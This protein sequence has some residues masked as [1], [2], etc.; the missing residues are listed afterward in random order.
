MSDTSTAVT[1]K[2]RLWAGPVQQRLLARMPVGQ[3]FRDSGFSVP[4]YCNQL[5]RL[6]KL[7]AQGV[8]VD[9]V[10]L[11]QPDRDQLTLQARWFGPQPNMLLSHGPR[12]GI[13]DSAVDRSGRGSGT[14]K[15]VN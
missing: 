2:D 6:N 7:Q 1:L 3:W 9:P 14:W 12:K 11:V 10:M 13:A 15:C 8:P 5:T 4:A